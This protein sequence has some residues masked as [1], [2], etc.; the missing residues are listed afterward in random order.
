MFR[1][2]IIMLAM[3]AFAAE[4]SLCQKKG[5]ELLGLHIGRDSK[6]DESA[7]VLSDLNVKWV[8]VF[9]DIN[10]WENPDTASN[11]SPAFAQAIALKKAGFRVILEL[12]AHNGKVP[13]S[14][15]KARA[16][17]D[18]VVRYPGLKEG[19]DVWEILN[20]INY[21]KYWKGTPQ[22]YVQLALKP[23]WEILHQ[24]NKEKI[25]G[26][27]F[28]G[29]QKTDGGT[30]ITEACIAAGYL[31][32][33][34]YAGLHTYMKSVEA[35][36]KF[37]DAM[38]KVYG[39]KPVLI[40]EWNMKHG[41]GNNKEWQKWADDLTVVYAHFTTKPSIKAACFYRLLETTNE[42]G[43]PGLIKN[44]GAAQPVFYD[45]F[46]TWSNININ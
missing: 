36:K 35:S 28:T 31:K 38:L 29:T 6:I 11:R 14:A 13:S 5:A 15:M 32:Y 46:K 12:N 3:L 20:E 18:W 37:V 9:A 39:K 7:A 26:T 24:K 21:D 25:L 44:G 2:K 27:S 33:C 43:W 16:Y 30:E 34:D 41:Y 8:R 4:T 22:Q 19:V 17:F 10:N 40:T 23:A 42:R 45:M 1:I